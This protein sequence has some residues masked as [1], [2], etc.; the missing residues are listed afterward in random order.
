MFTTN[1]NK[2]SKPLGHVFIISG[3]SGVGKD[4][5]A[6]KLSELPEYPSLNFSIPKSYTTRARRSS[7]PDDSIY[8]FVSEE[9]F[10]RLVDI[11]ML[12][13]TESHGHKYGT[14]KSG[15]SEIIVNGGNILKILD[16]NGARD[17][18]KRFPK[19][20]TTIYLKP[21]SL[22]VLGDRLSGRGSED[23]AEYNRRMID[24]LHELI[25]ISD[26]DYVITAGEDADVT[27]N[28][29]LAIILGNTQARL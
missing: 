17:I 20:T 8:E 26:Y 13:C 6:G 4:Y 5:I 28:I 16:K 25:D 15:L 23:A 19:Y 10:E 3:P 18:K 11:D 14:S 27:V 2:P 12:E 29:L 21:P 9:E 1:E 24:S 7:D 22:E